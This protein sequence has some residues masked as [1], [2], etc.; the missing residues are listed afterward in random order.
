MHTY[1]AFVRFGNQDKPDIYWRGLT[2]GQAQWRYNWIKRNWF[3]QFGEY[4]EFGFRREE[5]K[6]TV[7]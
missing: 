6:E 7:K 3:E 1:E 4:R 2:Y 5:L